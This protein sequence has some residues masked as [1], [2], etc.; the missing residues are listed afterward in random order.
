M[1]FLFESIKE[2][3]ETKKEIRKLQLERGKA[4][5]RLISFS[6]VSYD[7]EFY[8]KPSAHDENFVDSIPVS[9][10]QDIESE[11]EEATLKQIAQGKKT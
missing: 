5:G 7:T 10:D 3:D 11:E 9:G 4:E 6:E 1:A 2:D 8:S